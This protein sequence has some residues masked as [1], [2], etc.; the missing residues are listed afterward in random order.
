[1]VS[2]GAVNLMVSRTK[3]DNQHHLEYWIPAEDLEEFNANIIGS[4]DVVSEY[5]GTTATPVQ[6]SEPRATGAVL[7]FTV[8]KNQKL[9]AN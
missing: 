8:G 5:R 3:T 7:Q 6:D 2:A 1:L 4:I 9:K